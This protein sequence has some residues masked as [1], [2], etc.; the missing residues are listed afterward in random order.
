MT[1]AKICIFSYKHCAVVDARHNQTHVTPVMLPEVPLFRFLKV[2][3]EKA[4][5]FVEPVR[6][7]RHRIFV[8][9]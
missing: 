1:F 4:S 2:S 5:K 9:V 7:F 8:M 3:D 6:T